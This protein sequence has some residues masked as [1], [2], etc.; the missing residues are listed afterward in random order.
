MCEKNLKYWNQMIFS[1]NQFGSE[2]YDFFS[3]SIRK[4]N[5]G[6]FQSINLE[7]KPKF[8]QSINLEVTGLFLFQSINLEVKPR[9]DI[10]WSG[11]LLTTQM[12]QLKSFSLKGVLRKTV[13]M[14]KIFSNLCI[15][16]AWCV[17]C[18]GKYLSLLGAF[19][20]CWSLLGRMEGAIL[21]VLSSQCAFS[22]LK[23]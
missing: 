12:K 1:V 5:I 2:T 8:F 10:P 16:E 23:S 4:W 17:G 19:L 7:V 9:F 20:F 6:F 18:T 11:W 21:L 13:I 15:Y 14:K 22:W 3:Q